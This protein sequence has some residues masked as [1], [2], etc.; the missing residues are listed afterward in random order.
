MRDFRQRALGFLAGAISDQA[1]QRLERQLED[2]LTRGVGRGE[3]DE[4]NFSILLSKLRQLRPETADQLIRELTS[5]MAT[6]SERK[7]N[8]IRAIFSEV[9]TD[10]LKAIVPD[11]DV[12]AAMTL[13]VDAIV[14][15]AELPTDEARTEYAHASG[16]LIET[17]NVDRLGAV[18]GRYR[19]G[20]SALISGLAGN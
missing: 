18:G 19:R 8:R 14:R 12:E 16:L 1:R 20:F 13:A 2:T 9:F 17:D 4:V 5:W 7:R 3:Q 10:A 11:N 6:L 15:V